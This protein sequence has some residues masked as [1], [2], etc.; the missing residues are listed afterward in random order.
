[1]SRIEA[2]TSR[3]A[4]SYNC[5]QA[6]LS[7]YAACFG[8]DEE[9]ALRIASGFGGG[10]GR[11]AE[12][13]GAVTGALMVLGL[14]HGAVSPDREA[15][16]RVYEQVREFAKRFKARNGSLLCRELL[17][18]DIGT[19]EGLQQAGEADFVSKICPKFVRDAAEILDE[20]LAQGS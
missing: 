6:V 4:E 8:L 16:E 20:M 15:K 13:C 1:M 3:F 18:C 12:T 9:T 2:A 11:R 14:K 10:M 7:A 5:A 19:P 17:G